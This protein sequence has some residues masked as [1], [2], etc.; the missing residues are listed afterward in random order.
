MSVYVCDFGI[1]SAYGY[2]WIPTG[3]CR[4]FMGT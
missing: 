4:Y 3:V 2:L 1:M